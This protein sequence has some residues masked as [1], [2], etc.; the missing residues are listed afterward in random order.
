M[1]NFFRIAC[2]YIKMDKTQELK[3]LE[4]LGKGSHLAFNALFLQ[5][6][7]QVKKFLLGFLKSESDAN[8]LSQEIFVKIWVQR[9]KISQVNFFKTYLYSMAR[10]AL[11]NYFEHELIKQNYASKTQELSQ[12]KDVIESDLYAKE[13]SL[14]IDTTIEKMPEQRRRVFR[15]SRYEGIPNSEIAEKLNISKR[16]VEN[17][18]TSALAELRSMVAMF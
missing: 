7:P 6:Y 4:Q 14:L 17:H 3:L 16:T 10:N 5:Y 1:R 15:M 11:F 2:V 8:D 12:Y 9:E 18:I 13:L